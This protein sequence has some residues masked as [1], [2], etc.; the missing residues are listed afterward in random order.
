[1]LYYGTG[2]TDHEITGMQFLTDNRGQAFRE[3]VLTYMEECYGDRFDPGFYRNYRRMGKSSVSK[4][5][6]CGQ[7]K[8][9]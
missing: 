9:N 6:K 7:K 1:M 8:K 3:Q 5:K 2:N 4:E